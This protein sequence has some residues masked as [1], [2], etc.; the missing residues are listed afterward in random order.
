MSKRDQTRANIKIAG[1]SE[2]AA[3]LFEYKKL[4]NLVTSKIRQESVAYNTERVKSANNEGDV[5]KIVKE[6]TNLHSSNSWS[7]K[8]DVQ[9][10]H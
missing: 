9:T 1:Q 7:L 5:W 8:M 4:R 3:L 2:K 10:V 6:V